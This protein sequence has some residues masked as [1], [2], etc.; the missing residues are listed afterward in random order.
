MKKTALSSLLMPLNAEY[1]KVNPGWGT[2]P[3]MGVFIG[4]FAIFLVIIIEVYNKSI[5]L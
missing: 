2:T 5:F 1:G 4:L 3:I